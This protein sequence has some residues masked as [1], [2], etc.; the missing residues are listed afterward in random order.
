MPN[1]TREIQFAKSLFGPLPRQSV[2]VL[3]HLIAEYEFSVAAG[4]VMHLGNGWYVT[5]AGLL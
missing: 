2:A 4:D 5:H 3:K 1:L